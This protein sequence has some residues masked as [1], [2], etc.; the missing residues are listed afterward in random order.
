MVVGELLVAGAR[1][2]V[3]LG[4]ILWVVGGGY[5]LSMVVLAMVVAQVW[6]L[7]IFVSDNCMCLKA[8]VV[9]VMVLD[10]FFLK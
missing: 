8:I 2:W 1:L 5:G 7:V 3:Y 9:V 10:V 4:L 6:W